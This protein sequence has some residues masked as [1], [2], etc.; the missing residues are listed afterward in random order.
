MAE[1]GLQQASGSELVGGNGLRG[2]GCLCSSSSLA[3]APAVA[4]RCSDK[5]LQGSEIGFRE[6]H[7]ERQIKTGVVSATTFVIFSSC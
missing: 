5:R 7:K 1:V 4:T 3:E 2:Q 6:D